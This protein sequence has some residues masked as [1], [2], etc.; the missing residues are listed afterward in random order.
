MD[1][2]VILTILIMAGMVTGWVTLQIIR[3][4][5]GN[6]ITQ[7]VYKYRKE[8]NEDFIRTMAYYCGDVVYSVDDTISAVTPELLYQ[9]RVEAKNAIT[10]AKN[11]KK[12]KEDML[13]KAELMIYQSHKIKKR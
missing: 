3:Y 6:K 2:S 1:K 4:Y 5:H 11:K 13:F 8:D 7:K 10:D 9:R 12:V